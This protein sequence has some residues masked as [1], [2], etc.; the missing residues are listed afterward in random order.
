MKIKRAYLSRLDGNC[1]PM[2]K[3]GEAACSYVL[4]GSVDIE[5]VGVGYKKD[6]GRVVYFRPTLKGKK[7]KKF[8][9]LLREMEKLFEK[10]E[11][12]RTYVKR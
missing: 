2:A 6:N 7:K 12:E 1:F 3:I 4:E 9:V 11:Q 5:M 8:F 10:V